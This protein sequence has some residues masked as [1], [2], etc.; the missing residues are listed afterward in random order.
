MWFFFMGGPLWFLN[1]LAD[2]RPE[3]AAPIFSIDRSRFPGRSELV[4]DTIMVSI[5]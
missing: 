3:K 2:L 4:Y 1:S 5:A